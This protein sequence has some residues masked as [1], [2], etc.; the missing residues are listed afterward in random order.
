MSI[1]QTQADVQRQQYIQGLREQEAM[2][3]GIAALT[4]VVIPPT[5]PGATPVALTTPVVVVSKPNNSPFVSRDLVAT[6]KGNQIV[7]ANNNRKYL[8]IQNK[9]LNNPIYLQFGA[10]QGNQLVGGV[11]PGALILAGGEYDAE[12][13]ADSGG[14]WAVATGANVPIVIVEG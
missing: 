11:I 9:D 10:F 13:P 5:P 3:G 2:A 12:F 1:I 6:L 14:I 4:P 8:L 7:G